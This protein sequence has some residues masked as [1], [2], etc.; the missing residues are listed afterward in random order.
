MNA[1]DD[2]IRRIISRSGPLGS[3]D[4]RD[5]E[6]ELRAHL[7][8]AIE[9]ARSQGYDETQVLP[10]VCE[11]FGNADEIAVQF[12]AGRRFE[13]VATSAA[14]ALV[15]M[16]TSVL[17]VGALIFVFQL[18]VAISTGRSPSDSF[19]RLR[20]ELLG[21]GSLVL[22]YVG[23]YLGERSFQGHRL[24]KA[25]ALSSAMFT[26]LFILASV[27]LHLGSMGPV[28]AFVAGI[29]ARMLQNTV[30]RTVWFLGTAAPVVVA[31]LSGGPWLSTGSEIPVLAAALVRWIGLTAACYLLTLLSRTHAARSETAAR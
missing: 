8:D 21:F 23:F 12:A 5:L 9:E 15:L 17:T 6:R 22:G 10:V 28:L 27:I 29:S 3:G 26:C 25:F 1:G 19:P 18:L 7:E 13:R 20:E 24:V 11:R 4:R 2:L 14:Y 30:L 16:G 31:C